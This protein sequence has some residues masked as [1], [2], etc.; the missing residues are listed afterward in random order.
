[1]RILGGGQSLLILAGM[2]SGGV[3]LQ[4]VVDVAARGQILSYGAEFDIV[5]EHRWGAVIEDVFQ[6]GNGEAPVQQDG[7]APNSPTSELQLEELGAVGRQYGNSF[8]LA[9][10][11]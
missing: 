4:Q 1:M 5:D 10:T 8:T 3:D 11:E 9:Y 6:L 2:T 7:D